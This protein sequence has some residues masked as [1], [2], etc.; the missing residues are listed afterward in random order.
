MIGPIVFFNLT[1]SCVLGGTM[2]GVVTASLPIP[3]VGFDFRA[4][5]QI[6]GPTLEAAN[7]VVVASSDSLQIKRNQ[8]LIFSSGGWGFGASGVYRNI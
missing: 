5:A 1:F 3:N 4:T 2:S 8:D 6:S 7:G